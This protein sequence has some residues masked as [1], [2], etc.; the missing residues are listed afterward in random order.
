M[1][2]KLNP[3]LRGMLMSIIH[4]GG[5]TIRPSPSS[6]PHPVMNGVGKPPPPS[7]CVVNSHS[8]QQRVLLALAALKLPPPCHART[9]NLAREPGGT[10]G[11]VI[12]VAEVAKYWAFASVR[13]SVDPSNCPN[14]VNTPAVAPPGKAPAPV[15]KL[16]C[17]SGTL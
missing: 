9:S 16:A 8:A 12:G 13:S 14:S 5:L 17:H 15:R 1:A 10:P 7:G 2:T 4:S 11:T 3:G 6:R